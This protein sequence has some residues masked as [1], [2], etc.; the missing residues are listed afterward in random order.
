MRYH[1]LKA[2]A[3]WLQARTYIAEARAARELGRDIT[4][5]LDHVRVYRALAKNYARRE[6]P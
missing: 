3:L 1:R 2:R 6:A 5:L 4:D